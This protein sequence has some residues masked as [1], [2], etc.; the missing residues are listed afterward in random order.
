MSRTPEGKVKDAVTKILK[1]RGA[2]YFYPVAGGFGRSGIPDIII[3]Y[4]GQFIS[5]EC[6]ANGNTPTPLQLA[7]MG[8]IDKARGLSMV[9]DERN[10]SWVNHT[11]DAIDDI[12]L[13]RKQP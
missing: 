9:V 1:A 5:I 11:L 10:I 2:Y 3:C 12:Q 7:E 4:K 6:K 13:M 8:K